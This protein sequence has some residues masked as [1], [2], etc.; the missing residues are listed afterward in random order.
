MICKY[1]YLF[2]GN[3]KLKMTHRFIPSNGVGEMY[4]DVSNMHWYLY[5]SSCYNIDKEI[6]FMKILLDIVSLRMRYYTQLNGSRL[7]LPRTVF[8]LASTSSMLIKSFIKIKNLSKDVFCTGDIQSLNYCMDV[9]SQ[10]IKREPLDFF[11]SGHWEINFVKKCEK[12]KSELDRVLD[13]LKKLFQIFFTVIP[14][15]SK[16]KKK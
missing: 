13:Q 6:Q 1:F 3:K 11:I 15:N 2:L 7:L 8:N 5:E 14:K 4:L 9:Y 16:L 12:M 10:F